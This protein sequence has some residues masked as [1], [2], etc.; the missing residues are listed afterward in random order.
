MSYGQQPY[1]N[2]PQEQNPYGQNPYAPPGGGQYQAPYQQP[3]Q[4]HPGQGYAHPQPAAQGQPAYGQFPPQPVASQPSPAFQTPVPAP[5]P[6]RA[7]LRR[8]DIPCVTTEHLPGREIDLALGEVVGVVVRPRPAGADLA[9]QLTEQRQDAVDAAV[10]MALSAQADAVVGLRFETSLL[11]AAA[12][13]EIVAYGTAVRLSP[14]AAAAGA[15]GA[16]STDP[17]P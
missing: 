8:R 12:S 4:P 7:T 15:A 5:A 9:V 16:A 13:A 10:A 17:E 6:R 11:D 2:P 14:P 1:G 3:S